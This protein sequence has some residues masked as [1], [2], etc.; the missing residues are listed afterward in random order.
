MNNL[1][2]FFQQNDIIFCKDVQ[3]IANIIQSK[4]TCMYFSVA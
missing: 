4:N 2:I 3:I 1:V